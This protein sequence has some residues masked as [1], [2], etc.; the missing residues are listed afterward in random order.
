MSNDT[1]SEY[2]TALMEC[3]AAQAALHNWVSRTS[4]LAA[5]AGIAPEEAWQG[6]VDALAGASIQPGEV[7]KVVGDD[8]ASI[9]AGGEQ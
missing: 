8:Y 9:N 3:A 6:I 4:K 2:R 1:S 7:W 5:T